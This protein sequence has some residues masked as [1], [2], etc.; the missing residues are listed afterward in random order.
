MVVL[1][2]KRHHI[3]RCLLDSLA[4]GSKSPEAVPTVG[5][6]MLNS[7]DPVVDSA[8]F[9][10]LNLYSD[11][12]VS[13]FKPFAFKCHQ[14][15]PPLHDG[16][17][18]RFQHAATPPH[19]PAPASVPV[20]APAMWARASGAPA[21]APAPASAPTPKRMPRYAGRAG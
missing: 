8:R 7:V 1:T 4:G 10:T 18:C 20:P 11:N 3:I 13:T 16:V 6:C 12:T 15:A 2:N 21:P 5:R 14:P 9:Q 19:S 17:A